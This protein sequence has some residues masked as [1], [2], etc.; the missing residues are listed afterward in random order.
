[1]KSQINTPHKKIELKK[2]DITWIYQ[3]KQTH[4]AQK[5]IIFTARLKFHNLN[6]CWIFEDN[7]LLRPKCLLCIF[8][9]AEQTWHLKNWHMGK[10]GR[11]NLAKS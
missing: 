3:R 2:N 11:E 6:F 9:L 8:A 7:Q 4:H 10:L 1:M 5:Q